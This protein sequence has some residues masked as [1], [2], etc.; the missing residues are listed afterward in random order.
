MDGLIVYLFVYLFFRGISI[1]AWIAVEMLWAEPHA[2]TRKADPTITLY[3]L[4]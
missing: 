4:F 3:T 2:H 1:A